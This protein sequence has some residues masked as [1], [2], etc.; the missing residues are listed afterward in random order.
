MIAVAGFLGFVGL[1]LF[2]ASIWRRSLLPW[3]F[4]CVAAWLII[5]LA[6]G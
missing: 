3:A 5:G 6:F 2:V 1:V 4:A